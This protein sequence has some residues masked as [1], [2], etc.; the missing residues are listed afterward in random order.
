MNSAIK[1]LDKLSLLSFSG[2]M[3]KKRIVRDNSYQSKT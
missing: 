1:L 3:S 2:R